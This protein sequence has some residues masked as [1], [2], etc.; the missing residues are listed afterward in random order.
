[1]LRAV[2]VSPDTELATRL[3]ELV[4]RTGRI[5]IVKSTDRYLVSYEL[6]RFLR[7][8][9]PQ[10]IFLAIQHLN[11]SLDTYHAIE[12]VIPGVQ[13][14][15]VDRRCDPAVLLDLMHIGI[16]EFLAY[17]FDVTSFSA[18]M[19][20]LE[21]ILEKRPAR[22]DICDNVFSF[23][24]SKAGAGTSTIA[25]NTAV[26]LSLMPATKSLLVDLDLN[27]GLLGFMLR[28]DSSYSIYE[29]AE[30]SIKLDEHLWPQLV[31]SVRGLDVLPAG[32][33]D[34]QSRVDPLQI[35]QLINFARRFYKAICIDLS[36]NLE[37]YSLEVMHESKRIFVVVTPEIPTLHLARQKL[38]LIQDMDLGS[39]VSVLLNRS[40]KRPMITTSQIEDLLGVPVCQSFPNDYRGVHDAVTLGREVAQQSELGKGFAQLA[41]VLMEHPQALHPKPNKRRFLEFFSVLPRYSWSA[42]K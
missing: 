11:R 10:V 39:R 36:G 38:R 1:M 35:R 12:Q 22:I 37:K 4:A 32:R 3:E 8:N 18:A 30:H 27:S 41:N 20:R 29:A 7:A 2:I 16:R 28:L 17:P 19:G 24:P 15:A 13:V 31:N 5:G 6:E 26:A 33:L 42:E 14:V 9:A 21:E 23:L 40:Q 25:L 34:P